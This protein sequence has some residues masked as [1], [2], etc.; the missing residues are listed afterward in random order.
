MA[1]PSILS[2]VQKDIINAN[3]NMFAAEIERIDG[4]QGVSRP[5]IKAYQKR[6]KESDNTNDAEQLAEMIEG[7]IERHGLPVMYYDVVMYIKYLK[8]IDKV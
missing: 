6:T 2:D 7:Y 5:I 1:R 3:I 4:M 8:T